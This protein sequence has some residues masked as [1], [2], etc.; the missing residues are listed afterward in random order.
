MNQDTFGGGGNAYYQGQ[1]ESSRGYATSIQKQ[2]RD[3]KRDSLKTKDYEN[4]GISNIKNFTSSKLLIRCNYNHC[5][6]I[7]IRS[8]YHRER[9]RNV[10]L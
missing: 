8:D 9:S 6:W 10:K 3:E 2:K 1:N 4:F 7:C 5:D